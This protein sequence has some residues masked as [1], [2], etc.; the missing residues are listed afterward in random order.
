MRVPKQARHPLYED[1]RLY[2]LAF[3]F[4]DI[5][6]ECSGML[7]IADRHGVGRPRSVVDIASGP[8]HHLRELARRGLVA[9]GIELNR[10]MLAYSRSLCRDENIKLDLRHA[11][12]RSF[13]LGAAV[14]LAI[15]LFD[16]FSHCTSDGDAV[17]TLRSAAAALRHGGLL[18]L[19]LTHPGDYFGTTGKRTSSRWTQS[20]PEALLKTRFSTTR[21]DPIEETYV[22][23]MTIDV[24]FPNGRAP[25][26][27]TDRQLHRM[28]LRG[29]LRHVA[30]ASGAF[31]IVGWYGDLHP[32]IALT[33]ADGAWRMV[34]ALRRR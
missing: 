4:R 15:C 7:A 3:G 5:A 13:R 18:L 21:I 22:A 31:D 12:M 28:W 17:A 25:K 10:E 11:D 34:A 26:R 8:A 23:S 32:S 19:E 6:S 24:R 27:I 14:D 16:S 9:H 2:D 30:Q 20:Y 29:S 1:P 33:P